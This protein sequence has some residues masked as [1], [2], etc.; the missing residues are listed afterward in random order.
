MNTSTAI[1]FICISLLVMYILVQ[2]MTF[3][4]FSMS[5]YGTYIA[6]YLFLLLTWLVLPQ[7]IE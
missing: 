6:F 7:Q 3:Y 2:I 4:G 5:S 1:G